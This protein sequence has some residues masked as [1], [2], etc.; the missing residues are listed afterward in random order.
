[1]AHYMMSMFDSI[2]KTVADLP[3]SDIYKA[4][5]ELALD[6]LSE[7][8]RQIG[9]LQTENGKLQAQLQMVETERGQVKRELERLQE[10]HA[11]EVRIIKLIEFRRGKRTGGKWL[12]FCPKCHLP[13]GEV[14]SDSGV[15][16]A[17]CTAKFD[18]CGWSVYP[19]KNIEE[20]T[21]ELGA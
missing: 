13:V 16:H 2:K 19:P 5:I 10:E 18:D 3:I 1:M 15:M 8:E 4:R 14:Q 7:A 12:A 20:I 11:E 17:F 9:V 6:Q 21:K